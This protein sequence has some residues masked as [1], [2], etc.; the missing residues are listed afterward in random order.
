MR[1]SHRGLLLTHP[2]CSRPAT[3]AE[4]DIYVDIYKLRLEG[5]PAATEAQLAE[6]SVLDAELPLKTTTQFRRCEQRGARPLLH[7]RA[8]ARRVRCRWAIEIAAA[9]LKV[10]VEEMDL[11]RPKAPGFFASMLGR[12]PAELKLPPPLPAAERQAIFRKVE[13]EVTRALPCSR[14]PASVAHPAPA[15]TRRARCP[16]ST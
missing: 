8:N 6:L 4:R 12:K 11:T 16:I 13:I 7:V 14:G 2:R 5:Y 9:E 15:P 10:P 3:D 1:T